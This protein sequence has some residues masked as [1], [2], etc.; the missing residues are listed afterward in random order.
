MHS[1]AKV[2]FSHVTDTDFD[3]EVPVRS[4][5]QIQV[6]QPA[7]PLRNIFSRF[8]DLFEEVDGE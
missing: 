6:E 4:E 3:N 2:C 1:K 5:E 8:C 7:E